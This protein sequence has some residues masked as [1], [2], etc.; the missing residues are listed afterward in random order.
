M[1][2]TDTAVFHE[3][4]RAVQARVGVREKMEELGGRV[5]RDFMPDQHREFFA[6]LPFIVLGA[7]DPAQ[8]P[9]ATVLAGP[10]GFMRS[11]D[12]RHLVIGARPA[13]FDPL[14]GALGAGAP[15]GLLGIQPHTRRRNRMNGNVGTA[16]PVGLLE[17]A[18]TQSFGN[19]PKYIQAREPTYV[20]P[21]R[22]EVAV[23]NGE[24]RLDSAGQAMVRAADT[25]FIAS[26]HPDAATHSTRSRGVDV[27]HRGGKPGFVK[28]HDDG[29]HLTVPDF[30]GNYLFQTIG[31]LQ[32]NPRAGLVFV[33][34]ASGDLLYVAARG[35]IVWDGPEVEAFA[36]AQ[37]LIKFE[38][39][40]WRRVEGG[41]PLRWTAAESSAFLKP[42]GEWS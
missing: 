9:W 22:S 40:R 19:C 14:A 12:P 33:D 1:N 41:L 35:S 7:L 25:F 30:V 24:R 21:D 17:I 8:Q 38:V 6:M 32:L 36:G 34:F 4:E 29:S 3:G 11:P 2:P 10:P 27:S 13:S 28:V 37:R 16:S 39:D 5:I 20:A 31:N 26:A 42:T 18:V 15:V 23:R